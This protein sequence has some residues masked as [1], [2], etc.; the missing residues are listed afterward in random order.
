ML[1]IF[2][3]EIVSFSSISRDHIYLQAPCQIFVN[4]SVPFESSI[5]RSLASDIQIHL[6]YL[7]CHSALF[8]LILIVFRVLDRIMSY[9][10]S[11]GVV[12][13]A[14]FDRSKFWEGRNVNIS[15]SSKRINI[16]LSGNYSQCRVV[17]ITNINVAFSFISRDCI[18]WQALH[19]I[20][21]GRPDLNRRFLLPLTLM[22]RF[23]LY[24]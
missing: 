12:K 17:Y 13:V 16:M 2:Q 23:T 19:Q 21:V 3:I 11:K 9:D 15:I 14:R 1:F 20:F 5:S 18:S 10:R 8:A 7:M 6:I 24:I 4:W 22:F